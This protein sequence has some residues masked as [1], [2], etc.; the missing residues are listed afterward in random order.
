MTAAPLALSWTDQG[1]SFRMDV[2]CLALA[3]SLHAPLM[4]MKFDAKK[5]T[6]DHRLNRLVGVDVIKAEDLYKPKPKPVAAPPA[7]K[8]NS[9]MDRL[10]AL[11][12][13]E[14]PPP[15]PKP[16]TAAKPKKIETG[17]QDI[18]LKA[19]LDR[20]KLAA[21][22]LKSKSGFKTAAD[23]NLVKQKKIELNTLGA[24]VAPLSAKKVGVD[25]NRANVK[26]NRG[27]FQVS[28]SDSLSSIGGSGPGLADPTAPSINIRTGR[29]GTTE[30]FSKAA[31]AKTNKG[32]FGGGSSASLGKGK[33]LTLRDQMIA[34][35]AAPTQIGNVSSGGRAGGVAGG[36]PGGTGTKKDAGR[37]QGGATGS[38]SG[39]VGGTG[40]SGALA[41]A[42]GSGAA[43]SRP[44]KRAKKKMFVITGQLK[45]RGIKKQVIPE[46]PP[47]MQAKGIEGSVILEFTVDPMGKVKSNIVVRRSS[48]YSQLDKSA[49]KALKSWQFVPLADGSN[50]HEVGMIT[51]NYT[52]S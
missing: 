26:K 49:I 1:T 23:P 18:K 11:V 38:L 24:G 17:P 52:L 51:F 35:H 21:P 41:S 15:P 28:K 5:K 33:P 16:K 4:F 3:L 32:S 13:K 31:T 9:L 10:K 20:P 47:A 27:S 36:V 19:N 14:P 39:V 50:R 40:S 29:K 44:K 25:K 37:F 22:K 12:K 43:I 30:G 6:Q 48:G 46:Y 42:K 8:G 2:F 34:K 45:D 7:K